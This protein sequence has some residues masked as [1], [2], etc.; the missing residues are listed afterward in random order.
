MVMLWFEASI[1][2][3]R[4][5]TPWESA[6]LAYFRSC[7]LPRSSLGDYSCVHGYENLPYCT[8]PAFPLV[9][10]LRFTFISTPP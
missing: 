6:A 7:S 5:P 3:P 4:F 2:R 8:R 10:D 1:G 9:V